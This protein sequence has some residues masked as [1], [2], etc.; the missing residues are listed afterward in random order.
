MTVVGTPLSRTLTIINQGNGE[1]TLN[2]ASLILP[3]GFSV[4][5]PFATTVAPYGGQTTFT[6]R[7]DAAVPGSYFGILSFASNDADENPLSIGISGLVN[8]GGYTGQD[9]TV[10]GMRLVNDTGYSDA[11]NVTYDPRL[12]AVVEGDFAAGRVEVQFDHNADGLI[13]GTLTAAQSGAVIT[14]DPI[15]MAPELAGYVGFVT[16]RYRPVPRNA[17]G[18]ITSIGEWGE[19][20]IELVASPTAGNLRVQ[21]FG[22]KTDTGLSNT[23]KLTVDPT[24]FAIVSGNLDGGSA[25]LEFDHEGDGVTEGSINITNNVDEFYYDPRTVEPD[26]ADEYGTRTLSYRLLKLDAAGA[27]VATGGWDAFRFT[28][29][30][31]PDSTW[32]IGELALANDT[33]ETNNDLITSDPTLRGKVTGGPPAGSS[34]LNLPKA[35]VQFDLNGDQI[36]DRTTHADADGTFE[37]RPPFA[38]YGQKSVQARVKQRSPQ[39]QQ[40]LFGAWSSIVFEYVA[41]AAPIVEQLRLVRDTGSS[42]TDK[43][44]RDARIAGEVSGS[45]DAFLRIEFDTG[46]DGLPEGMVLASDTGSF[47]FLPKG[48]T[49]G[50]NTVRI[51][52][53][54][55][56]TLTS[57]TVYSA[58]TPFSFTYEAMPL[59]VV[60][61]LQL[62]ADTGASSTDGITTR[63]TLSASLSGGEGDL[64]G[65]EVEFD[66]NNDGVSD[67]STISGGSGK[68]EYR[69][70]G[71]PAGAVTIRARAIDWD[72]NLSTNV[73]GPWKSL[74]FTLQTPAFQPAVFTSFGLERDTGGSASDRITSDATLRGA[75][76]A[77]GNGNTRAFVTLEFD[78]NGDGVVD[79]QTTTDAEG[80]F[81]YVPIGLAGGTHTLRARAKEWNYQTRQGQFG[82]WQPITITLETPANAVPTVSFGLRADTG[83]SSA[84]GLTANALLVGQVSNDQTGE[85]LL[86]EMDHNGDGIAEGVTYTNS[87]GEFTYAPEAL[88]FGQ[89]TISARA[90]EWNNATGQYQAGPWQP[91]SF[92]L[93]DQP[94]AP[95]V[96]TAISLEEP[97]QTGSQTTYVPALAGRISNAWYLD[98]IA[99]EIDLNAD[100]VPDQTTVTDDLGSFHVQL[101]VAPGAQSA[102]FRTREIEVGTGQLLYSSWSQ[103]SFTYQAPTNAPAAIASLLLQNDT[104]SSSTDRQT[105]DPT[106]R[107]SVTNEGPVTGLTIQ[108]DHNGDGIVDGSTTTN[109]AGGFSYK[110]AGL[111]FGIQT[112]RSRTKEHDADGI[113]QYG[114]WQNIQ[115]TLLDPTLTQ[116]RVATLALKSD[117]GASATDGSTSNAE[118]SGQVAN[119]GGA[120]TTVEIDSNGDGL[121]DATV[122]T[123]S[124][125]AFTFQ[126]AGL[127]TGLVTMRARVQAPSGQSP[128]AW[129]SLS[130]VYHGQPDGTEAQ[131]LVTAFNNFSSLWR[132]SRLD[133][134]TAIALADQIFRAQTQAAKEAYDATISTADSQRETL[135][136]AAKAAYNAVVQQADVSRTQAL[137]AAGNQFATD[138]ANFTGDITS[139]RLKDFVWPDAPPDFAHE[140]PDDS[141]QPRPPSEAPNYD[142][143]GYDFP[144]DDQH[145]GDLA[146]ADHQYNQ[147]VR[148]AEQQRQTAVTAAENKYKNALNVAQEDLNQDSAAAQQVYDDHL[149]ASNP[150]DLEAEIATIRHQQREMADAHARDNDRASRKHSKDQG[151][152]YL[153]FSQDVAAYQ[154]TYD[155]AMAN[156]V[157]PADPNDTQGWAA[158]RAAVAT[159]TWNLAT[160][161]AAREHQYSYDRATIDRDAALAVIARNHVFQNAWENLEKTLAEKVANDNAWPRQ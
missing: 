158:Y 61:T 118:L 4:V 60:S 24:V 100:G 28:I 79:G 127:S 46:N 5:T 125:G 16:F 92:T 108:F 55:Y 160:A 41:A 31:T 52:T 96:I 18:A 144:N 135:I 129:T 99:I 149:N 141:T 159:I 37:F 38:T 113:A 161:Y 94:S 156:L 117:T 65:L 95:A 68:F 104:G 48:L 67:G 26:F 86:V 63:S 57:Q 43:I 155:S 77:G 47:E 7:L 51:R 126:P 19:F 53:G 120:A 147:A 20:P 40:Y 78:H 80:A 62:V 138:L 105:T 42:S 2:S 70:L 29:E 133:Y 106:L 119:T 74:S 14:Y 45:D 137:A 64:G 72:E 152:L 102:Q 130:F 150:I 58:W 8:G 85:R 136:A 12:T 115:F 11:D 148:A 82:V 32:S 97:I 1:L 25:R 34:A 139:F 44:T 157:K 71:L 39:Y 109:D 91:V 69:P 17:Q 143:S 153:A 9:I 15:A 123:N 27:V 89:T 107:G 54:R 13:D 81:R 101:N 83:V 98:G 73:Q 50:A 140:I 59:P 88:G 3:T 6:I 33:G 75:I 111:A 10:S 134:Q 124:S 131:S 30:L 36:V 151:D 23:D 145:Q 112:I 87:Q 76:S 132:D 49:P 35:I 56:D 22:L 116:K 142:G 84:D 121:T 110:P 154:A 90:I 66:H 128:S 93:E 122:T 146:A 114:S 103:F 21:H